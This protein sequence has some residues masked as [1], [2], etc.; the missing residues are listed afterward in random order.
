MGQTRSDAS[1]RM[2]IF[3][4][5]DRCFSGGSAKRPQAQTTPAT[6][7]QRETAS[8]ARQISKEG[9]ATF[10]TPAKPEIAPKPSAVEPYMLSERAYLLEFGH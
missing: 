4:A 1:Q 8:D 5:F 7:R 2:Q 10:R 9:A 3:R 6:S